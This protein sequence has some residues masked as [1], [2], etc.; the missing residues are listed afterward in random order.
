MA[1]TTL[2]GHATALLKADGIA[3][4]A[5]NLTV[6]GSD[7]IAPIEIDAATSTATQRRGPSLTVIALHDDSMNCRTRNAPSSDAR[8]GPDQPALPS[9]Q[10]LVP[11]WHGESERRGAETLGECG[12]GDFKSVARSVLNRHAVADIEAESIE[13]CDCGVAPVNVGSRAGPQPRTDGQHRLATDACESHAA[14][15]PNGVGEGVAACGH[16]HRSASIG[17]ESIDGPLYFNS[18]IQTALSFLVAL[19]ALPWF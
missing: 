10:I 4:V 18:G 8:I 9:H 2:D 16:V 5:T 19:N 6:C 14:G 1:P 11:G 3:V 7:I 12:R 13:H 15:Q 17:R